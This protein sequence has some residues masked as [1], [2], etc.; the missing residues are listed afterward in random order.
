MNYIKEINAFY[1]WLE[2]NSMSTS[3]IALWHALMHM[4]NKTGWAREFAVATSVLSVKTGLSPRTISNARNE[5]KQKGRIDWRSRKGNQSAM[6]K[7][8]PLSANIADK[9]SNND[10]D[11][12]PDKDLSELNADNVS[13]NTSDNVSNNASGNASTL[14]KHKQ[15]E[16]KQKN[17]I[18]SPEFEKFWNAYPRKVE[19]KKAFK[20]W[21]TRLKEG[22][23]PEDLIIAANNYALDCERLKTEKKFIK[24]PSTFLGPSCPFEDYLESPMPD[25]ELPEDVPEEWRF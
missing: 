15:N 6:Y 22:Y 19:K 7:L 21:K 23:N 16:T 17:N 3:A 9:I 12:A 20:N 25:M 13:D 8:M 24:H 14:N 2:T 5:L 18:Y 11:N 10:T 1:D 4:C